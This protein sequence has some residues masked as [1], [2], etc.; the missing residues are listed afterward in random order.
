MSKAKFNSRVDSFY[1]MDIS[2]FTWCFVLDPTHKI[3][4]LVTKK[5]CRLR[6]FILHTRVTSTKEF[7]KCCSE[8]QLRLN[9]LSWRKGRVRLKNLCAIGWT[10]WTIALRQPPSHNASNLQT[11][12]IE[13]THTS[14]SRK[15]LIENCLIAEL[16]ALFEM[17]SW[18]T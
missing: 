18:F 1:Y 9:N 7:R 3:N 17:S 6:Y 16:Q 4:W 14:F 2:H 5:N 15:I 8:G 13:T 10:M 11:I 12:F